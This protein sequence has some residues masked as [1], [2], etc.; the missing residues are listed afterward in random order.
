MFQN[1]KW[2]VKHRNASNS[3]SHQI[4]GCAQN[5]VW[6]SLYRD[7]KKCI[8]QLSGGFPDIVTSHG[9]GNTSL[10][11]LAKPHPHGLL[12]RIH[13][14]MPDMLQGCSG[15]ERKESNLKFI[16]LSTSTHSYIFLS[17]LCC[18]IWDPKLTDV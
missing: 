5:K 8:V 17:I 16:G 9:H 7:R 11:Q 14:H 18:K 12:K 2:N 6:K 13:S 15:K 3:V 4:T 1:A 10:L